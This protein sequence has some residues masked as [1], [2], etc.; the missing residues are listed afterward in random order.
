LSQVAKN[1]EQELKT[2]KELKEQ[3]VAWEELT[4]ATKK[5]ERQKKPQDYYEDIYAKKI[6]Y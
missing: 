1:I 3:Y 2:S 5:E 6:A 4:Q